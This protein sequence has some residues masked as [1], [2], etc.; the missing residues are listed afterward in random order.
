[1]KFSYNWLKE[2]VPKIPK[3][4]KLAELLTMHSFEV[5]ELMKSKG[6]RQTSQKDFV[7]NIDVL[8]NRGSDCFSHIGIAREIAVVTSSKFKIPKYKIQDTS[9]KT[10]DFIRIE[11]KNRAACLRYTA[12]VVVDV[13]VSPSSKWI[14]ERLIACGLRPINNIVDIINYVMLETGQPLHAFNGS[15]LEGNKIIVRFA[16]KGEKITTLDNEKYDLDKD[17]LVIA[18]AKKPVAI[19]GIKGGV[20]AEIDKKTKIVVIES[21]NFNPKIIRQGSQKLNLKTDASLR[22]EH[23]IDPN[24]TEIAVNRVAYLMQKVAR[25]KVAQDIIDFYPKKVL[26]Q[27]IKLD[28]G[29]VESLLGIKIPAKEIQNILKKLNFII[30]ESGARSILVEVPSFRLDISLPE[31]LIEE[32][33]RISGFNKLPVVFPQVA[34]IPPKRNREGFW[35]EMVKN[36]LKEASF[37]EVY[38]YSFVGEKLKAALSYQN[39]DIIEIENPASEEQKYLRPSLT[40]NLLKNVKDN[41][42]YFDEIRIFELGKIFIKNPAFVPKNRTPADKQKPKG[43]GQIIEKRMLTGL[44]ARKGG[45]SYADDFY[46]LKGMID[47]LLHKMGI[48]NIWYDEYQPVPKD[49]RFSIWQ[50]KGSA[51][52]KIDQKEIGFLGGISPK[53]LNK[54][55]IKGSV[56]LFDIDFELL[57]Q[58]FSEEYEFMPISRY[59]AAVRDLAILVPRG[60]KVVEVLNR[61]NIG[62]GILV[63][64]VDLF[65]MYEG[66][67]LP[68]G[69]KNLAF[70]IIYQSDDHT[71]LSRE[72]DEVHN[73]IIKSLEKE[74][75]WQ[76]RK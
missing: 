30:N 21:A 64:D 47:S 72:I 66:D 60:I 75:E 73:K 44:I 52:I 54:L 40:P 24:L 53:I 41:F 35:K 27:K 71:L 6:G 70:H 32:I 9:Y 13:K 74:V 58:L 20:S 15:K 51:E 1:M 18:D 42:R 76:V 36:A 56:L 38:N 3:P 10:K 49:S 46:R 69:K 61:I 17:I 11:V 37:A 29:Y 25:G 55:K 68:E 28:L 57:S 14:Q 12:R 62:G 22:F 67:E 39:R 16:K 4:D 34:L 19:A 45:S 31:D 43:S 63:R 65:D 5:K 7:L 59:P 26:P 50:S 48:S 23:G 33:G 8:P 2:F